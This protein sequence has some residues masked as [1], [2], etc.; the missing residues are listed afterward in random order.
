MD[1]QPPTSDEI[2]NWLDQLRRLYELG[3]K[4]ASLEAISLCAQYNLLMPSWVRSGFTE[5]Y[6]KVHFYQVNGWDDVFG[7]AHPKGRLKDLQQNIRSLEVYE[8]VIGHVAA[9]GSRNEEFWVEL[10]EEMKIGA[11]KLKKLWAVGCEVHGV[12]KEDV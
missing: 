2:A 9:G 11:T 8:R 7:P 1:N 5:Q 4:D 6:N 3:K 12:A 10:G